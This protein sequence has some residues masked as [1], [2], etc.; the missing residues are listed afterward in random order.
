MKKYKA[1][2]EDIKKIV[3]MLKENPLKPDKDGILTIKYRVGAITKYNT[4][5]GVNPFSLSNISNSILHP[6]KAGEEAA[7]EYKEDT[8]CPGR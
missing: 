7:R 2:C 8:P 6:A 3:K 5:T 1:T 4:F